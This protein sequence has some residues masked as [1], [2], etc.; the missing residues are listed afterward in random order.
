[1]RYTY[2][3]LYGI[4]KMV[5]MNSPWPF[6]DGQCSETYLGRFLLRD[7]CDGAVGSPGTHQLLPSSKELFDL[8]IGRRRFLVR[9]VILD[10]S[11]DLRVF[12]QDLAES[13]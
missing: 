1:M 12:F 3:E 6:T 9:R 13:L 10:S 11:E 7:L 5:Y 2:F 8:G 4:E